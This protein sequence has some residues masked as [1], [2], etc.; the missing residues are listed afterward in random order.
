MNPL[1]AQTKEFAGISETQ[2]GISETQP[3]IS[4]DP[5]S[6]QALVMSFAR[7]AG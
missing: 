3:G 1:A 4:K 7:D 2:P 6:F 5:H